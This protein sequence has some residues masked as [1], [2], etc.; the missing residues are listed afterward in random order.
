MHPD[1]YENVIKGREHP[2]VNDDALPPRT[3]R[4]ALQMRRRL[5]FRNYSDSFLSQ[6]LQTLIHL[7]IYATADFVAG[8]IYWARQKREEEKQR[9]TGAAS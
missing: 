6:V 1:Q 2:T 8:T 7:F 5:R 3:F 9:K 4:E